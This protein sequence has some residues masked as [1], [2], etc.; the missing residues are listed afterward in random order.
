[1]KLRARLRWVSLLY[2]IEGFPFGVVYDALP[3]YFRS[4]GVS[5]R[6]IGFMALLELPWS[7]KVLW[8]PLV[9]RGHPRRWILAALFV[10]ALAHLVIPAF[11]A[12]HPGLGLWLVLFFLTLA[13]ATQDIAIDGTFVRLID[14]GEEGVGNGVRVSAYRA[15]IV[16]GG[17]GMVIFAGTLPWPVVFSGAAALLFALLLVASRAPATERPPHRPLAEW[18]GSFWLWL[19]RPSALF[20]FVFILLYKLG[21]QSIGRMIR[22]FW[23]DRG[24]TPEEI[25][26][27]TTVVGVFLTVAGA[28]AGG[29]YT[30][31]RGIFSGVWVLGLTQAFSNLG[32]AAVAH[33]DLGRPFLYGASVFE[34]FTQGLGTAALLAF[35]TRAC[36]REHAATQ[37]ALLSAIFSFTRSLAGAASGWAAERLGFAPFFSLTFF[38]SFP[39]YLFLPWVRQWIREG[40]TSSTG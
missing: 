24:M 31:K 36:D 10:V 35:L 40:E 13:S 12:S 23:V 2:F 21:D 38:L 6:Q 7:I 28:L 4:H 29:W 19:R 34:S 17:G 18:A 27:F 39:A 14:R 26:F 1:M 3:V 5:L 33:Y 15:A 30:S 25:G 32:Y 37:Y 22:P 16:V 20:V 9:D 11:D 8:S